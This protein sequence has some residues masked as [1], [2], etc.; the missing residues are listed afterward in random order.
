MWTTK[1]N[2]EY[3]NVNSTDMYTNA[4]RFNTEQPCSKWEMLMDT[5]L[6]NTWFNS[7]QYFYDSIDYE[8]S[9]STSIKNAVK[10]KYLHMNMRIAN[11]PS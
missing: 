6:S 8:S 3:F 4:R 10:Y 11:Q 1:G 5:T 9:N 2:P 7:Q